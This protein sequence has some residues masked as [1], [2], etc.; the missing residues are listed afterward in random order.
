MITSVFISGTEDISEP[1]AIRRTVFIEEQGCP[2]EEEYDAFDTQ[3]LHLMVYADEK[4][5]ATG[6]IW[7]DGEDFRIGRLAVLKPFRGQKIGDLALRLLLYKA[8]S[9]GAQRIKISA[10]TYI[11]PLYRKFGF[12]EYG[13][14]YLEAG[15]KHMAM[16]V[17][18]DEVVYPSACGG[19]AQKQSE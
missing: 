8:F 19:C 7:H 15:I 18:K 17:S 3:A 1:F 9:S 6:R 2:L 5:A 11:M 14:E 16:T 10:Q 13:D 12:K 4:P